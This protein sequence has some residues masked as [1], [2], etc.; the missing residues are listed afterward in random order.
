MHTPDELMYYSLIVLI[1]KLNLLFPATLFSLK[2]KLLID[3]CGS[4]LNLWILWFEFWIHLCLK[5]VKDLVWVVTIRLFH[6]PTV[7]QI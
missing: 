3:S 7:V 2:R 6:A 5:L 4:C 1:S